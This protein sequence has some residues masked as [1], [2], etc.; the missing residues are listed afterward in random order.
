MEISIHS[1]VKR[2][3]GRGRGQRTSN[4]ISI[5]SLVK[6][7]TFTDSFFAI[8]SLNFNPLP[9]KE[10]DDDGWTVISRN[11]GISIHSLVK[12]ETSAY[13]RTINKAA[14]FNPLPRK[15]G[16]EIGGDNMETYENFNPLPRKEGDCECVIC[17]WPVGAISI[18]SL[19]KRE[20]MCPCRRQKFAP[21]SIHSLVKRETFM[22]N[23]SLFLQKISIHSLVKR[24]TFGFLRFRF[25]VADFNPLPRKEGD[26]PTC[27][28]K[29]GWNYFNPLPRKEGDGGFIA[30]CNAVLISI[31]S[32]VKRE[33]L[34]LLY[35]RLTAIHF[36][37][38]PRKE[39]DY[40][41]VG[42]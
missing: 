18:H 10:G 30:I 41:V 1:L 3:T 25:I 8:A 23:I 20:T 16:D 32:L 34:F 27:R 33:T 29:S 15:E 40:R 4:A 14:H 24:E 31:H 38:L 22:Y 37:P 39:G 35:C 28:F 11:T 9:R 42:L 36:N 5:H 2:E 26:T 12:R 17:N 19:V 6:R 21:I 7:E 13:H